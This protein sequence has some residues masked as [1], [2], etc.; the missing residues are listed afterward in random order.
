[1]AR[2]PARVQ[3][4]VR[5]LGSE[6]QYLQLAEGENA[7]GARKLV[8]VIG[9][10]SAEEIERCLLGTEEPRPMTH[11]LLHDVVSGLGGRI[12]E[13][14]ILALRDGTYFAELRLESGG[15]MT[16]VDCRPS[17]GIAL[18]LR[19]QVPLFVNEAVWKE[20]SKQG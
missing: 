7:E 14:E 16:Q 3:R 1:M 18:A 12:L 6:V 5:M 13:L 19:A 20:A 8:M 9:R 17:D 11:K 15:K 4:L 10:A 2:T